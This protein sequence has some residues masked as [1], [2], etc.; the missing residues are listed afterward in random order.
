MKHKI[1]MHKGM[2]T[3]PSLSQSPGRSLTNS[4]LQALAYELH[5]PLRIP[6]LLWF[7]FSCS[8]DVKCYPDMTASPRSDMSASLKCPCHFL[9]M[10]WAMSDIAWKWHKHVRSN[11]FVSLEGNVRH[12]GGGTM[13]WSCLS[14]LGLDILLGSGFGLE[15]VL[16]A[17]WLMNQTRNQIFVRFSYCSFPPLTI[18]HIQSLAYK[19]IWNINISKHK[20][21]DLAMFL[22]LLLLLLIII[23]YL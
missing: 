13:P 10:L 2:G 19:S 18:D 7:K 21:L 6:Q 17:A 12:A 15:L 3:D 4:G 14:W 9:G 11:K 1:Y 16:G 5:L 22:Y 8:G 20:A 23:I